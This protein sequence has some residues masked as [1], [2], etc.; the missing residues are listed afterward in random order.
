MHSHGVAERDYKS[1]AGMLP[2][3]INPVITWL[4]DF[5]GVITREVFEAADFFS[6]RAALLDSM[7]RM[8]YG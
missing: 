4:M 5:R 7:L 6:S 2:A 3:V 1:L 8:K